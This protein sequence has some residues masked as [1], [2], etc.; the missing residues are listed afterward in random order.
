MSIKSNK[1]EKEKTMRLLPL[2][3]TTFALDFECPVPDIVKGYQK[4]K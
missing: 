2:I 3:V 1:K 4:L